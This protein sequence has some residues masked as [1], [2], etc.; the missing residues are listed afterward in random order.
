MQEDLV[1][2]KDLGFIDYSTGLRVQEYYKELVRQKIIK[3][4]FLLLEHNP[5]YTLGKKNKNTEGSYNYL[6]KIAEIYSVDRGGDITF[7]G[8][9]QLVVYPILNLQYWLKIAF[10][11]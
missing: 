7:H 3:G 4:A 6:K 10:V 2:I 5:V 1:T 9:G 11:C 8:P